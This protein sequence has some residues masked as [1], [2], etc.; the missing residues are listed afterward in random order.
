VLAGAACGQETKPPPR[1]VTEPQVPEPGTQ[2]PEAVKQAIATLRAKLRKEGIDVDL[3]AGTITIETT[4]NRPADPLEYLLIHKRGKSHEALFVTDVKPSL[5]NT[6]FLLLGYE[7]GKNA[8]YKP[9]E[10]PPTEEE[11]AKG[12]EWVEV[13]P[14]EGMPLYITATWTPEVDGEKGEESEKGDKDEKDEK[15]AKKTALAEDLI[16]D[17]TTGESVQGSEWI[18]LGGRMAAMYRNEPPVFVA[19]FEGN[20]V[21]ICYLAPANHLATMKQERARDDQNWW[22]TDL[23]PP[24]DTKVTLRFHKD[25]PKALAERKEAKSEKAKPQEAGPDKAEPGKSRVRKGQGL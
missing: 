21:S 24:P 16:R 14:P 6:A 18:F 17:L 20:L 11:V 25:P 12:A 23:C 13:F 9:I 8:S 4:V 5:L 19:D 1:S 22:V 2:D 10:P 3:E 15:A 7:Q